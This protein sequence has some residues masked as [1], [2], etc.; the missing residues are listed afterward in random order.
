[1]GVIQLIWMGVIQLI[2]MGVI[3]LI[4]MGAIGPI[5]Y[6]SSA[7]MRG[8]TNKCGGTGHPDSLLHKLLRV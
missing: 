2:W 6:Q 7:E 4:W 3:Q 1:M 8:N 5:F